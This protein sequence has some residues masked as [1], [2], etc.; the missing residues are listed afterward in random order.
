MKIS[1]L[2]ATYNRAKL[3]NKLYTSLIENSKYNVNIEWIIMDDGSTD[4]T[5]DV[6][7]DFIKENKL[8]IKYYT[9]KNQGKMVAINQIVKEATGDLIIECDSDDYFTS[10]AF[11]IIKHEWEK[12]KDRKDIYGLCFLKHDTKGNNMGNEFKKQETT[13]F[14]L[15]FKEGETGEKAIAFY[16][17]IRKKYSHQ[18]EQNERF[19]TEARMYHKMDEDYK[20]I[21][22]NQPIM[23][24]EYQEE[25]YTQNIVQQFKENPYGY[26]EYFKEILQKDFDGVKF[27]KRMY[28]IKHYILFSYLT[29][30]YNAKSIKA[31]ENKILYYLLLVPGM[32]KSKKSFDKM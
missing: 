28:A 31:M 17:D 27:K 29:K 6:V 12:N 24:C 11:E 13:M 1:I 19:V 2:T 32:I 18:L 16:S 15:Y 4:E 14:D 25:G 7:E 26:Y 21:C 10:N 20:M 30:K 23:I 8:D 9:Q 22:I 5:K 3:L